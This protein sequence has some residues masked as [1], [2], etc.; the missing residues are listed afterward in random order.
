VGSTTKRAR[1]S[2]SATRRSTAGGA[3]H[4]PQAV[5][6][7]VPCLAKLNLDLRVLHKRPD[8]FHEL[9]TIFQTIS[10]EDTLTIEFEPARRTEL[11]LDSSVEIADNIVIKAAQAVLDDM[12]LNASVR[13]SL[14]KA[15]PIGGGLGGGSSDA[16]SVLLALPACAQRRVSLD[17]LHRLAAQLGSDIPFFL[18][19]GTALGLGRGTELYPIP[20]LGPQHLV[21]VATG[22]HVSTAEAYR[23]LQR[24]LGPHFD[25]Q[26]VTDA[27]TSPG[28]FPILREFQAVVWSSTHRP[29]GQIR[30]Q[31]DF[32]P[33]VF[34]AHSDLARILRDLKRAGA[35]N[36]RMTGSGSALFGLFSS[37]A[38]AREVARQFP[39]SIGFPARFV[40]RDAY[41]K[42]W[43]NALGKLAG[44]SA[45]MERDGQD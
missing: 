44:F 24:P 12:K 32:E 39:N 19:G 45:L 43:R 5:R 26:I 23:A 22:I 20:D 33:I 42:R 7:S 35:V 36:A 17:D 30:L 31:N 21:V 10:L 18:Y 3:S 38:E 40:S 13:F 15:I 41:K 4:P 9:R 6:V 29:L 25:E 34:E 27:L 37:E 1:Q 2:S 14:K 11:H 16:A 28:S 8:G